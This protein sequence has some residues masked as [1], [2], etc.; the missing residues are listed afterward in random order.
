[1]IWDFFINR[2]VLANVLAI[3]FIVIGAVALATLP[4]AQDPDV[5]PPNVQVTARYPGASARTVVDAV[6]LPIEQQVNGIPGMIYMQSFSTADGTYTLFV[7]FEIGTNIDLAEIRVQNRLASALPSL[8]QAVQAQGVVAQK[9]STNILLFI[10]LT[11][12]DLRYNDLYLANYAALNIKDEIARLPGVGSVAVI[13][14]GQYSMRI[15]LDPDK[16]K[17]RGL[18]PQDIILALQQQSEQV[19][20][21]QIGMPPAPEDLS[22]QYTLEIP[23]RLREVEEFA[24]VAVKIN[25]NG[26]IT[27]LRDVARVE[28]GAQT[29]GQSFR[30]DN[31]PAAGLAVYQSPGANAVEVARTVRAKLNSLSREFPIGIAAEI[32]FDISKFIQESIHEIYKTMYEV[33][34]LVLIVVLVF[35]QSWR[36]MLVP[37]TALPV[38]IFAAFA[39]I[40]A[41]GFTI[42]VS[43]MFA[44][45]LAIG[46]VVDDAIVVVEATVRNIEKGMSGREA[47]RQAMRQLFGPI[48][49][50]TLV[51]M[52]VF[53]P[54][55]FLPGLTGRMYAQFA[56]VIAGT[57]LI[58]AI[59]ALTL[60]PTQS[61][62]WLRP[63]HLRSKN[64]LNRIF[65]AAYLRMEYYYGRLIDR[66]V[67]HSVLMAVVAIVTIGFSGYGFWRL[68]TAFIP[69]EDQGYMVAMVQ[70]PEGSSLARTQNALA[71]VAELSRTM[72]EVSQVITIAGL[73]PLDNNAPL[74]SSGIAYIMLKDWSKAK[75]L[76]CCQCTRS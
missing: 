59:N 33:A 49:G 41:F 56:L 16:M 8:P 11:S 76:I 24:D 61:A 70:L 36:A 57:G 47:A 69:V 40:A 60:K 68:P 58:S 17:A 14:A 15:W 32:P 50:I 12:S 45:V 75:T 1:M 64:I 46:V 5:V 7:T 28:L 67:K 31:K 65:D 54:A 51:L 38:T 55:A 3:L 9:I 71:R 2:P 37:A 20:A 21:G 19:T 18:V 13:G 48:V 53:L 62:M 29:Y 63:G 35:L 6:A 74:A 23:G 4:V 34:F 39:A 44:I 26:E 10:A 66:M 22:F 73:S 42:N 52:A 43:S 72:P 27:R 25:P 30:I